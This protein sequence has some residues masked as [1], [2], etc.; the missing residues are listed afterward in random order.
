[1]DQRLM[2]SSRLP[3]TYVGGAFKWLTW[4]ICYGFLLAVIVSVTHQIVVHPRAQRII[5]LR[6]LP[7]PAGLKAIGAPDSLEPGVAQFF[8][9]FG[10]Q[11][12]DPATHLLFI[13][14]TGPIPNNYEDVD[15]TFHA[16]NP[17]DIARDG[18]VLVYDLQKQKLVGRVPVPRATGLL[19]VPEL[20]KV[21]VSGSE[22][23]RVYSFDEP[24]LTNLQY[25][26]LSGDADPATLG[27]DPVHRRLFV[28]VPGG[29]N[30]ATVK[31]PGQLPIMNENIDPQLESVYVFDALTLKV[32]ARISI[33]TLPRL[34]NEDLSAGEDTPVPTVNG[35]VPRFGYRI[36]QL[37][38]DN[39]T[40]RVYLLTEISENRNIRPHPNPPLG[41]AE[42]VT[43]DPATVR[44]I[45]RTTLPP[46]CNLVHS[47]VL[48]TAQQIAYIDCTSVDTD[49]PLIQHIAR[50]NLRTMKA[51]PDNPLDSELA[52][53]PFMM[54]LDRPLHLLF[55]A[56]DGGIVVFDVRPGSFQK[57]GVYALVR[58]LTSIIVDEATQFIY[59]PVVST[60]GRPTLYIAQYNP[61]G[62]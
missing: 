29:E 15:H 5:L 57:L 47:L 49:P 37:Q 32:Q 45:R 21:F 9:Q 19:V 56:C 6:T 23:S 48:D 55:E 46:S 28:A 26:Q 33:G 51:F 59:L 58:N 14:H 36:D 13:A 60:G 20:H 31:V 3:A 61:Y 40:H 1:M 53:A 43:I 50:M 27:Y 54:V 8:D 22:Q 52:P 34:P 4:I 42:L 38:Y 11:G 18:N 17:A 62:V 12:I 2:A 41:A 10:Q 30:H 25:F 39:V 16:N 24:S 35:N 44:I 7:L